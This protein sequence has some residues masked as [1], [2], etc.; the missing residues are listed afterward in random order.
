[1]EDLATALYM[2]ISR[3]AKRR[4]LGAKVKLGVKVGVSGHG[5]TVDRRAGCVEKL[6]EAL[7][8]RDEQWSLLSKPVYA[9]KSRGG[10]KETEMI[11]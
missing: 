3:Q 11:G 9:L 4:T 5:T 6:E 7:R 8:R 1:M 2:A 10:A